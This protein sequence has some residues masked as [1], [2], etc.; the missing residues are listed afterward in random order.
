MPITLKCPCGKTLRVADENAGRR[1][2]CPA[3]AAVLDAPAPELF[4]EV[5]ETPPPTSEANPIVKPGAADDD[6]EEGGVYG[7]AEPTKDDEANAP[8]K[9]LPNFRLGSGRREASGDE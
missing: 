5:V 3:C 7:L 8:E 9:K 2:K 1:V 4:F 6:D